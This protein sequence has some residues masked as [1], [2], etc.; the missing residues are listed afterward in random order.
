MRSASQGLGQLAGRRAETRCEV[1]AADA[2]RVGTGGGGGP[3]GE[4]L[5]GWAVC[6]A[7]APKAC[8]CLSCISWWLCAPT[9]WRLRLRGGSSSCVNRPAAHHCLREGTGFRRPVGAQALTRGGVCPRMVG[10]RQWRPGLLCL[11][12]RTLTCCR[13]LSGAGPERRS[14]PAG[15]VVDSPWAGLLASRPLLGVRA[16]VLPNLLSL[17]VPPGVA[18]L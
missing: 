7:G 10:N 11:A 17:A 2:R 3:A 14:L 9:G 4:E 15:C 1:A 18:A 8:P 13:H 6:I 12:S 16:R 5:R